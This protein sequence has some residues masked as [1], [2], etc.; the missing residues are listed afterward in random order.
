MARQPLGSDFAARL[1]SLHQSV[2][3]RHASCVRRDHR[4]RVLGLAAPAH[5][6]TTPL[7][8][9]R[10]PTRELYR[11]INAAFAAEWKQQTGETVTIK[12]SHG[13]SGKQSRGVIDGLEADVATLALA[14]DIDALH[15]HETRHP[16]LAKP[17]VAFRERNRFDGSELEPGRAVTL[18][19]RRWA[20]LRGDARLELR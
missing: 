3:N 15:E 19:A 17:L 18:D 16:E 12:Q 11:H 13:G 6:D 5:A 4:G 1:A 10:D 2:G 8:V 9:S 14:C 7:N 20:L